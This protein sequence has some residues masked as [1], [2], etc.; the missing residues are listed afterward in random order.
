MTSSFFDLLSIETLIVRYA[1]QDAICIVLRAEDG[2]GDLDDAGL[3]EDVP[4]IRV[5]VAIATGE[6]LVVAT[7]GPEIE[8]VH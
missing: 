6:V 7:N 5:V 4:E 8:S 1:G 3:V 2:E